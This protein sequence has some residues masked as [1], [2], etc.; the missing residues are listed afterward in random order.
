MTP[1]QATFPVTPALT[2][3]MTGLSGAG[4]STLAQAW[5]QEL[6]RMH[7][8][9]CI[10]DGDELRSGLSQ[11]LGF[12]PEDR[13]EQMR[14]VAEIAKILNQSGIFCIVA[15]ISPTIIGRRH[16]RTI[17]GE[18]RMLEVHV[19]TPLAICQQRDVKG[20]YQKAAQQPGLQLT[21]VRAP[22]EVPTNPDFTFDTSQQTVEQVLTQLMRTL[23]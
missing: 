17:I 18:D 2:W 10:L 4:K 19:S 20:L 6:R 8:P 7:Y 16:A 23:S 21:G 13:E 9:V 11:D 15:L 12:S 22:Y 1:Y 14:R 5:A 3:W